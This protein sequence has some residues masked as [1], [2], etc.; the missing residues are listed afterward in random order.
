MGTVK[1]AW[2]WLI[3]APDEHP[4]KM[5]VVD[6]QSG[7]SWE[8]SASETT[9][10]EKGRVPRVNYGDGEYLEVLIVEPGT[11][12]ARARIRAARFDWSREVNGDPKGFL[13]TREQW[14]PLQVRWF[15]PGFLKEHVAFIPS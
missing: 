8:V 9:V 5:L 3:G 4:D 2:R 13:V 14:V 12:R 11:F 7:Q 6:A 15:H 1:R 10:F